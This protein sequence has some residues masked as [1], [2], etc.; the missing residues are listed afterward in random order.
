[1]LLS[2]A[3]RWLG[4]EPLR[5][6]RRQLWEVAWWSSEL[7]SDMGSLTRLEMA[8]SVWGVGGMAMD[9]GLSELCF[10]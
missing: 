4:S 9:S 3:C 2:V 1:M 6:L 7:A 5:G 10:S 8:R